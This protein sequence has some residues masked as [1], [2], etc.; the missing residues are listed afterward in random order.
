MSRTEKQKMLAGEPYLG[1]DPILAAERRHAR[2]LLR[3]YNATDDDE[4]TRRAALLETLFG[5]I[6]PGAAIEPAFRCDYGYNLD[7][8][9][10]LFVNFDCV[11]RP[12][13]PLRATSHRSSS[14]RSRDPARGDGRRFADRHRR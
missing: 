7:A 1:H 13:R 8:G 4:A 3:A 12:D 5:A 11:F 9:A 6:G 14:G 10:N 2:G